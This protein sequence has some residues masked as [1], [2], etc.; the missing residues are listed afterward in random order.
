MIRSEPNARDFYEDLIAIARIEALFAPTTRHRV[1]MAAD[2][3]K[4][5]RFVP[6]L[7]R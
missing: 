7:A 4:L 2:F 3:S 5:A 1:A 6:A